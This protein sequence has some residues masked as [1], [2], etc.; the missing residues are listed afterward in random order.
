MDYFMG[1]S[2][3]LSPGDFGSQRKRYIEA[4]VG[5]LGTGWK[6]PSKYP[7]KTQEYSS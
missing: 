1:I 7:F 4:S 2:I 5:N 6:L 3:P